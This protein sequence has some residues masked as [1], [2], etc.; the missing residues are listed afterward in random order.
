[1]VFFNFKQKTKTKVKI[2]QFRLRIALLALFILT[3]NFSFARTFNPNDIINDNELTAKNSLS[4]TAIQTFLERED[5]VLAR[6]GLEVEG[7]TLK[8]SEAIWRAC[9]KF[10]INPKFILTVL[11]KE[12][13][14]IQK[15]QAMEKA[16]DWATGYGCYGG[17]CKEKY[18]G[19]YNQIEATAET[20]QIYL[21]K[22]GQFAFNVGQ[23]TKTYDGYAVT[24]A[25]QATANL[26]IYTPHVGN[27]PEL[28]ISQTYGGNKL[29][30]R[31]WH[32]YF[33][34]QKF[35]DGQVVQNNGQYWLIADNQKRKFASE[36]IFLADYRPT[37]AISASA[38]DLAAYPN[39]APINFADNSLVKSTGSG[40]I[41]LISDNSKRPILDNSALALLSEVK[42]SATENEITVV[43]DSQLAGYALGPV[44][45][46][47][48]IYPQG[49]LFSDSLGAIW[50]VQDGLKHLVDPLIWQ[51]KFKNKPA[52]PTSQA[53]LD[54]YLLGDPIKLKDGT[55]IT[56]DGKYYLITNGERMR[57]V[58]LSIFSRIFGLDKKQNALAVTD[59]VLQIHSAGEMIDY[60]DDTIKDPI[61]GSQT[62][63]SQAAVFDSMTPDG[64]IMLSGQKQTVTVKFQN[65]GG[66]T[67]SKENIRLQINDQ[68]KAV[69]SF[70][71]DQ[72]FKPNEATI[73]PD[74]LASFTFD[75]TAPSSQTGIINQE[76]A[77]YSDLG[78]QASKLAAVGKLILVKP[79]AG[80]QITKHN[81]PA[82]ISNVAKP[83]NITVKIK[84]TSQDVVWLSRKAALEIY[85]ADGSVSP[86]YD[87][88]DWIRKEVAAVPINKS[89]I[90][91]GETGEFRFTLD[92]RNVKKGNYTLNIQ[93]KLLDQ[94]K[95]VILDGQGQWLQKITVK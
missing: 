86:F 37:D 18:R 16:L 7:Q 56:L 74:Q 50:L 68:G 41:F 24:P 3:P 44:I 31:I 67:W 2:W 80:G 93:L 52:E 19:F 20:Q 55:F 64:L 12:Q 54:R 46:P 4:K 14:L 47:N 21:E 75:L 25:N 88:Y 83:I 76:F 71:V 34:S 58:D 11:E 77:L 8:A 92:A 29:F 57:I 51:K 49:K 81:I 48:S 45:A 33:S 26:Y 42:M 60:I 15:T 63:V 62:P 84:N 78:G 39:G 10:N 61:I 36:M 30:W 23:T 72:N 87:K 94:D 69:S 9:Q 5:S 89:K 38:D 17:S 79:A 91:P 28:G 95:Q 85:N 70:G 59:A 6:Y 53:Q 40:Q 73:G 27:A 43:A 32:R 22:A 82:A 1:M 90:K 35:L 66:T 65:N 13:G